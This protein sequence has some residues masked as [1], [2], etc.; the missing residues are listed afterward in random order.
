MNPLP[1][2]PRVFA[3]VDAAEADSNEVVGYGFTLPDGSA[4]SVSWP[5]HAGTS[6]YSTRSAEANA[7]LRGADLVWMT[8]RETS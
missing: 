5:A 3:L 2:S 4:I 1:N 6:Y 8:D 7:S